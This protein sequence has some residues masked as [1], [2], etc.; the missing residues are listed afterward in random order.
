MSASTKLAPKIA[1]VDLSLPKVLGLKILRKRKVETI[2]DKS[3]H[4]QVELLSMLPT[5]EFKDLEPHAIDDFKI[6]WVQHDLGSLVS[7]EGI[8]EASMVEVEELKARSAKVEALE[9][10]ANIMLKAV[11]EEMAKLQSEVKE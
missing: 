5:F 2:D 10:K 11:E 4:A 3:A 8:K 6:V 7:E 1:G 9:A